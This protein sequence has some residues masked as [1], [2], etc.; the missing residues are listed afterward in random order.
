MNIEQLK[1]IFETALKSLGVADPK[2][3]FERPGELSHGD[4]ATN[5]AMAYAKE[6]GKNPKALAEEITLALSKS[7]LESASVVNVSIAGPGFINISFSK[8]V[9]QDA[10]VEIL[11][12]KN[13]YGKSH[14]FDGKKILVEH[15]SPNLFK[16][17]H[18]GHV[19]NNAIGESI[20]RIAKYS[21]AEVTVISYPSDVS[22]GIA[23]AVWAFLE[24]GVEKLDTF[25]SEAEKLMYLGDCYVH[26]TKALEEN[27]SLEPRM[28][29]IA[30][31]IYEKTSGPEYDA[32]LV[33]R[34]INLSYFKNIT[35]RI[36]SHFDG[37]IFESEAGNEGKEIIE[38]HIGDVFIKSEGAVIYEGEQDGLHT[39]V[40][41]NKEGYPTYEAKD[42]GLLSLKFKKFNPDLSILVT[43]H[44][45]T[46]TYE[47]VLAA[48]RKINP[49]WAKKTIH[50]THGRMSF[51]GQKMSSRLG[52]V[53]IAA[54]LLDALHEEVEIKSPGMDATLADKIAIAAL[55]FTIVRV[56]A[57]KNMNFDPDTSLS[58]EGDSGP[59]L[60][61]TAVRARSILQKAK[62]TVNAQPDA[63][64]ITGDTISDVEKYL[65]RF[66]EVVE[67]CITEWA[68]HYLA[69]YLL[70][71]AQ[72]FNSWYAQVKIIDEENPDMAYHLALTEATAQIIENGLSLLGIDVPE[73]M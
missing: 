44:E 8:K 37:Y 13:A 71:L 64:N 32:Y 50:K 39:R 70:A 17:F 14:A 40:F 62:E 49:E 43:D 48:S 36:G 7:D 66:P 25:S 2:V 10:V 31:M 47:V 21:G 41:M 28:R 24:D 35:E 9:Y 67:Q 59:Y 19:M 27:P 1:T 52:G 30:K 12:K 68:P 63:K 72:A 58:F 34:D 42:I 60:Q 20:A 3:V 16:P 61:Y 11:D 5:V 56:M 51:K 38:A 69:T 18:I 26:G 33:G 46:S 73:K 65:V 53:P 4:Y 54:T 55:K 45:Q 6:L 22:L 23:K 29:E 57:G 15:S